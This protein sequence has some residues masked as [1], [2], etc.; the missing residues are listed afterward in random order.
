MVLVIL[1][2]S[3]R[4]PVEG[5]GSLLGNVSIVNTKSNPLNMPV[6][7]I[8]TTW[9]KDGSKRRMQFVTYPIVN[10]DKILTHVLV[11]SCDENWVSLDDPAQTFDDREE[12]VYHRELRKVAHEKGELVK[13]YTTD[14]EWNPDYVPSNEEGDDTSTV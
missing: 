11:Y 7:S 5:Q 10:N 9:A 6:T 14:P 8:E 1:S 4:D 12:E 3:K 2:K 13:Q